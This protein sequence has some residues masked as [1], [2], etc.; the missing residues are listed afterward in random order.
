MADNFALSSQCF[1]L[2]WRIAFIMTSY[3]TLRSIQSLGIVYSCVAR[4]KVILAYYA[5][6]Q[7]NFPDVVPGVLA[8]IPPNRDDK[9]TY[10]SGE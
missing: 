3:G 9:M 2:V 6:F 5:S 7:G 10:T 1:L 8:V 4:G